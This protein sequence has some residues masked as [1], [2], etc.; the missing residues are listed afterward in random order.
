VTAAWDAED[1]T[2]PGAWRGFTPQLRST[3]ARA[4]AE[5]ALIETKLS[6]ASGDKSFYDK[7]RANFWSQVCVS[8]V[9]LSQAGP[10]GVNMNAT[11]AEAEKLVSQV[12]SGAS[13]AAASITSGQYYCLNPEQLIQRPPNFAN[14]VGPAAVGKAVAV[15]NQGGYQVV[16]VRSRSLV[17]FDQATEMVVDV[18]SSLGGYQGVGYNDTPLIDL[19]KEADIKV[20]PEYGAW[21][22][23]PP[24]PYA[25]QDLSPRQLLTS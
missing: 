17:P 21:D 7:N 12:N 1:A 6:G 2:A 4:D 23:T 20:N 22:G 15:A 14:S 10:N 25:P 16:L 5:H 3:L 19:L 8:E 24:S 18:V 13:G 9:D 11:K